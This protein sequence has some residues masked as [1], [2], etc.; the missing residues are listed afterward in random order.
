MIKLKINGRS[1]MH[2]VN[3]VTEALAAVKGVE[4]TPEVALGPGSAFSGGR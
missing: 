4:E 1:C 3:A 2:C